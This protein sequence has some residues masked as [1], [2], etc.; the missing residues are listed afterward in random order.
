MNMKN[1]TPVFLLILAAS[2]CSNPLDYTVGQQPEM[3]TLTASAP[4]L[5]SAT[6]KMQAR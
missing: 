2:A 3:I 6:L 1:L 4:G 5:K